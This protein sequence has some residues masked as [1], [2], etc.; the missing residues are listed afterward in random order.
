MV[1][2]EPSAMEFGPRCVITSEDVMLQLL[3]EAHDDGDAVKKA[4]ISN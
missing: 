2:C 4:L 3:R 1:S